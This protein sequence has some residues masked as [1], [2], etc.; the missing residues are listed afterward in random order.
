MLGGMAA[1]RLLDV[2]CATI[3]L[4]ILTPVLLGVVVAMSLDLLL[5]RRDRGGFLYR[6]PRISRGRSFSLLKFRT[7]RIEVLD[8]MRAARSHARL[9]EADPANLT[10]AGRRVL[11]PW[12][13]DELPQL[14][15]VLRGD[16]SLVGPRPWPPEM[17]ERQ[18][19]EGLTYRNEVRAGLTGPAQVTKGAGLRFAD[20]DLRYVERLRTLRGLALVRYDLGILWATVRV[21]VRGE[22]LSY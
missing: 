2:S 4:L 21:I 15:N 22:G 5:V 3:L 16:I 17:V 12:Y 11:K 19:A 20:L 10:W 9:Y 6:E 7:L 18:L 13:L 8:Q 14:F 1:K